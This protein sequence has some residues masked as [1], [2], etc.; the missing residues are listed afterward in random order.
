[1]VALNV[2]LSVRLA[3][4]PITREVSA[5]AFRKEAIGGVRNVRL[6]L[7]RP[8]DRVDQVTAYTRV[9]LHDSRSA[10]PIAEGRIADL[11]RSAA[12]SDGQQW[13]IVAF[14]AAQHASD[15]TFPYVLVDQS[16]SDGWRRAETITAG[17]QYGTGTQ[18][19]DTSDTGPEG[20]LLQFT[21]G[22]TVALNGRVV[23]RYERIRQ[24]AQKIGGF[25]FTR[26]CGV[27]DTNYDI[28]SYTRT[29]GGTGEVATT[30]TFTTTGATANAIVVTDFTNGRNT[31]DLRIL[32]NAASATIADDVHWGMYTDFWIRALLVNAAGTEITS[33][34][35]VGYVLAHT[36][37]ND[38]LGRVLDQFDG[39]NASVDTGAAYQIDQLA[40]PD[41]VTAAQVLEDLMVL[42]PAYRWTTGPSNSAGEYAFSWEPWPTTVRYE[43]TLDDGGSFPASAQEVYNRVLVRWRDAKGL[44]RNTF[45]PSATTTEPCAVLD[46]ATPPVIRQ[47]MIDL[48]D[49]PGS[50]AAAVRAGDNFLAD[51]NVPANAGTLTVSRP[52]RDLV[53]GAMVQPHEIEPGELIRVRGV[54]S[55]P[56]ALNAS[57]N[58]GQTV[59]RIWSMDYTSDNHTAVLELDTYSRTVA[60]ALARLTWRRRRKR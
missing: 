54:E 28:Q 41:G 29:D 1:L 40:Y 7:A 8:L 15:V 22:Q 21:Q 12:A 2:P 58:D 57:S 45:R 43:M 60:N 52:I 13:D 17:G 35:S 53:T 49:E 55:Y 10:E 38:L 34:Y 24:A 5:V 44:V 37:V 56:D 18:P 6:R 33:G 27:I 23:L 20:I 42:E 4:L 11:G 3:G 9:Y 39:A 47:A 46:N 59:F 32:H 16:I 51:H 30:S 25:A 31:L 14:G 50:A 19:G 48:G 36:V 26:D